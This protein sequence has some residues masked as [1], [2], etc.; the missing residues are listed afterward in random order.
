MAIPWKLD[1]SEL[2]GGA[3]SSELRGPY[4]GQAHSKGDLNSLHKDFFL[5]LVCLAIKIKEMTSKTVSSTPRRNSLNLWVRYICPKMILTI[6]SRE[7]S[8]K[9]LPF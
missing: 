9:T 8:N 3:A 2:K 4:R 1:D 6:F 5:Q 7:E